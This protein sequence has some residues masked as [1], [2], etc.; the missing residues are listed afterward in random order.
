MNKIKGVLAF[1]LGFKGRIGRLHYAIFLP[2]LFALMILSGSLWFMVGVS[3]A[4]VKYIGG[5]EFE[6][7][8]VI[9]GAILG[10]IL[11]IMFKY[12]H[13]TRRVHDFN[14]KVTNSILFNTILIIEIIATVLPLL[15]VNMKDGAFML[16]ILGGIIALI[17]LISLAFIKGTDGENN[18]GVR[19]IPFWENRK[20]LSG[21]HL[22]NKIKGV[23]SFFLGLS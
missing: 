21:V 5:Y 19:S 14:Y 16:F 18:F 3:I 20:F 15:G 12:S 8:F 4:K 10:S 7:L 6:L 22:I 2:F 17:C 13:L 11:T 9:L 1:F 23:F